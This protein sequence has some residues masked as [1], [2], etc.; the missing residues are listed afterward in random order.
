M[1]KEKLKIVSFSSDGSLYLCVVCVCVCELVIVRNTK[2]EYKNGMNKIKKSFPVAVVAATA[3][4]LAKLVLFSES[5]E[6]GALAH[7]TY[8]WI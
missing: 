6:R 8:V 2:E 3:S 1:K 5:A 4:P 7:T